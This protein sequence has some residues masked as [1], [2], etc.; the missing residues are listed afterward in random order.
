[1][2]N[3]PLYHYIDAYLQGQLGEEALRAFEQALRLDEDLKQ[4][5]K[6]RKAELK[7]ISGIEAYMDTQE[8]LPG[9]T[10]LMSLY[11]S[12]MVVGSFWSRSQEMENKKGR[13]HSDQQDWGLPGGS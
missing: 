3:A 4:E 8:N 6:I 5:V 12:L 13:Q 2:K 7:A 10:W 9:K 11:S 1:M